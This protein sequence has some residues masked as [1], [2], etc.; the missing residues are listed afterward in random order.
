VASG[1]INDPNHWYVRA[2]EMRALAH[3]MKDAETRAIMLRLANDYDS[4]AARAAKRSA[5]PLNNDLRCQR[6]KGHKHKIAACSEGKPV[7][8]TCTCGWKK[9]VCKDGQW[10]HRFFNS[11]SQ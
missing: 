4:L 2:A 3:E 5:S 8:A 9:T 1:F 11:C 6:P 7:A 10:C